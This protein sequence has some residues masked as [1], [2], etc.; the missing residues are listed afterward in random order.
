[1]TIAIA[2]T[3]I[4]TTSATAIVRLPLQLQKDEKRLLL[5]IFPKSL[6][7]KAESVIPTWPFCGLLLF[8][9]V[10]DP[11]NRKRPLGI[12]IRS[13]GGL[14][15]LRSIH[16]GD[17]HLQSR[18]WMMENMI[19]K[20]TWLSFM[21][22]LQLSINLMCIEDWEFEYDVVQIGEDHKYD[23]DI[24]STTVFFQA[25]GYTNEVGTWCRS[26]VEWDAKGGW[27][28]CIAWYLDR[29]W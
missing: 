8:A 2:T 13:R 12:L 17:E 20:I 11:I 25:H 5:F 26:H 15:L 16:G 24:Q 19:R 4:A 6:K 3:R 21:L 10:F 1:M 22:P 23:H 28:V 14:E 7:K 18:W 27:E 29:F 9:F